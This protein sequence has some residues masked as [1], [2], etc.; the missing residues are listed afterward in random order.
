[1]AEAAPE[2]E[3]VEAPPRGVF[4]Y[5][6]GEDKYD[7][8]WAERVY[9]EGEVP[10]EPPAPEEGEEPVELKTYCRHGVGRSTCAGGVY[11]GGWLAPED[12]HHGRAQRDELRAVLLPLMQVGQ[13][14][15]PLAV[16]VVVT[17]LDRHAARRSHVRD[18]RH[19]WVGLGDKELDGNI[20]CG[21]R[22][23][24]GDGA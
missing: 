9:G 21:P 18:R 3:E 22:V 19:A 23:R 12:G 15:E 2:G 1:M 13:V 5:P 4:V 20:I 17:R 6:N 24:D 7:G 10:P 11:D 8:E 14:N 16:H